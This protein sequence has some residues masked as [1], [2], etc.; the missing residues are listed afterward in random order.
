MDSD[1]NAKCQKGMLVD[2]NCT[3]PP[4]NSHILPSH[5]DVAVAT[6]EIRFL[7]AVCLSKLGRVAITVC[8]APWRIITFTLREVAGPPV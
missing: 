1:R 8:H 3:L 5:A 2:P 4:A 7:F 6:L